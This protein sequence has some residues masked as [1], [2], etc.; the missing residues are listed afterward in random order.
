MTLWPVDDEITAQVMVSFYRNLARLAPAEALHQA[1]MEAVGRI[2]ERDGDANPALW[3]AFI[4]QS[5]SGFSP[6]GR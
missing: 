3:A 4:L 1:Q 6:P 5:G 2:R